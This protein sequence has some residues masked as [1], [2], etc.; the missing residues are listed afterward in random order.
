MVSSGRRRPGLCHLLFYMLTF[1][2]LEFSS[3]P[4]TCRNNWTW[5]MGEDQGWMSNKDK[6]SSWD[7]QVLRKP[8]TRAKQVYCEV[9]HQGGKQPRSAES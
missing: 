5:T 1:A 9:Q 7:Q 8:L 3:R 4:Q 2:V 6:S